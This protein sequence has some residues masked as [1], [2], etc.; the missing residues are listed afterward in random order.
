MA[1]K[2]WL[3]QIA[4]G[5]RKPSHHIN[6]P[7][8]SASTMLALIELKNKLTGNTMSVFEAHQQSQERVNP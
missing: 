7:R 1:V 4:E 5:A 6:Q 2:H 8:I 3:T